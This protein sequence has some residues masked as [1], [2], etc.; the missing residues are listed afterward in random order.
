MSI[1]GAFDDTSYAVILNALTRKEVGHTL[2][3]FRLILNE[4][5]IMGA[6]GWLGSV[7]VDTV[8]LRP[9]FLLAQFVLEVWGILT[10]LVRIRRR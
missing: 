8:A 10:R 3:Y 4:F 9:L 2:K 1:Q 7:I 5:N 6:V